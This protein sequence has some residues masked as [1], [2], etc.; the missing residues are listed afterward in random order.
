[1]SYLILPYLIL[2][3]WFTISIRGSY[4]TPNP[5]NGQH[6]RVIWTLWKGN[7]KGLLGPLK[8]GVLL[9]YLSA[10]LNF[11]YEMVRVTE[12]R[13]EPTEK[14][15][16]L[17]NYLWDRQSDLLVHDTVPTFQNNKIVDLTLPWIYDH[18]AFLIAVSDE[19]ANINAVVKPF[20]W[21]IWLGLGV[22]IVCVIAVLNLMQRYLE[23]RSV[24]ETPSRS[25]DNPPTEKI[26]NKGG[27]G[28]QYLYV[29]GNLLSQGGP[30]P[31]KRLPYR[32]V[33]GVWTLAAFI[34]VQAYTSTLFT[35]VVTPIHHPLI[36]SVYDIINSNDIN[37]LVKEEGFV[38]ILLSTNNETGLYRALR[39]RLDSFP[40]S[41]CKV[42]SDCISLI[43]PESTNVYVDANVYL[44]D[45]IRKNFRK[46]GTCNFEL[47]KE[48]FIGAT[49]SLALS[50]N[51]P[52]TQTI[53]QGILEL[54]QIGLVDHWD[55]WFRPMPPQ[56]N[57]K[58][59][60]GNKKKKQLPLSLKNLSGTFL[61]L[62]A[63]LG[64]SLVA[65]LVENIIS[66]PERG[67]RFRANKFQPEPNNLIEKE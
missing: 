13:L 18:F 61:V 51:S 44:K 34:F 33:A 42:V 54:Q 48:K 28:K 2:V 27:T 37:L 1:M 36:N 66:I 3:V 26:V 39:A 20:Q 67:R 12:Y 57:G 22:S 24:I 16:G 56:C 53:S 46:T 19:T 25:N 63:G 41:R 43:T 40:K 49:A 21:P 30:C 6:L 59:R 29:F 45:E 35:Y 52:Y 64:L 10:R 32:L 65:F 58:P 8:G 31:S 55:S 5:L 11:T 14:G 38:N 50:K 9:E 7:P 17:F 60:S 47:A 23:Y 62:L 15:R 4:S